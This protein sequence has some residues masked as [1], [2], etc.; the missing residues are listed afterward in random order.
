MAPA[1]HIGPD[2]P[3]HLIRAVEEGGG[4]PVALEEAEGVVWAGGPDKLP[5]LPGSVRWVQLPA[6]GVEPWMERVRETPDVTFT[7]A[8]GAYATQVAELAL[9]LLIAGIRGSPAMR[10]RRRGT[11]ST[12]A[13]SKARR[14]RSSA[15]A[16]S[17]GR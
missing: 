8:T 16:G 7:S 4:R 17:A 14:W 3:E 11:R 12:T 2:D 10:A 6:A 1:I 5:E 13:R 9:G 15:P